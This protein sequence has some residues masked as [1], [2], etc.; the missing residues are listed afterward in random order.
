[1]GKTKDRT[2]TRRRA[3]AVALLGTTI[4]VGGA[5]VVA[6]G[7]AAPAPVTCR[8]TASD[9]M[10]AAEAARRLEAQRPDLFQQS[11]RRADHDDLRLAAEWTRRLA[12]LRPQEGC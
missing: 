1:M 11:P 2:G 7:Q 12:I 10:Q 6:P 4:G 9:L 8:A 3:I 5:F